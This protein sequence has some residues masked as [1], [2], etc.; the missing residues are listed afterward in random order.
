MEPATGMKLE[1]AIHFADRVNRISVSQTMAV[2]QEAERFKARGADVVDFGPGEP[3]FPTPDHIK[4]AAIRALDENRTKYTATPGIA[5][6][7]QA[8]CDWHAA[9]LAS[10]YQPAECI[11]TVGGKHAVFN[12]ICSLVNGGDEVV[13]PAPYWVSYP[14]IVKYAGGTPVIVETREKDGFSPSPEDIERAITP[15]TRVVIINSPCNPTGAVI[16]Q[17]EFVRILEVCQKHGV[18][19]LSDECYSHFVYGDA[20]PYSIASVPGSKE[21]VIIAGS[22]SKTFAMTG[23]RMGYALAP[24]PL[25]GA[26]TK[27]QSQS[28]SNPNSIA[29]YAALE[30]M[31]GPMDSVGVM[32]AEYARRRELILAGLRAIPGVTCTAPQ[33]AFYVFPNVS[34]HVDAEMPDDTAIAKQLL[35]REHVAVVPGQAFGAPGHVRISYATSIERIEEGLRRLTRFFGRGK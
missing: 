21:H 24:A 4:R 17:N 2:M 34:A 19:L 9:Q 26:I 6:L 3:D 7:R 5:P 15:R 32:L 8:I 35:E 29:Q 18:W 14:D 16:P 12:S 13:I 1:E 10:S 20:R 11:V 27:L 30:A 25:V 31:R 33:G 28:T 22:F 23:W